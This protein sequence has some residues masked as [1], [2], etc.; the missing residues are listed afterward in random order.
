MY[1]RQEFTPTELTSIVEELKEALDKEPTP[2]TKEMCIRDREYVAIRENQLID[3]IREQYPQHLGESF[4]A[5]IPE[6][7]TPCLLY[8]SRCV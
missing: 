1:K 7:I 8:T 5:N 3:E 6:R 4:G 2:E